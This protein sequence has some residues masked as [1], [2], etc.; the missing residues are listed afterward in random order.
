MGCLDVL[1]Q[2]EEARFLGGHYG[3]LVGADRTVLL[4]MPRASLLLAKRSWNSSVGLGPHGQGVGK[5][6]NSGLDADSDCC[7]RPTV[8]GCEKTFNFDTTLC[9]QPPFATHFHVKGPCF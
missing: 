8:V 1:L 2:E 7:A 9:R 5:V 6:R 4:P 3:R